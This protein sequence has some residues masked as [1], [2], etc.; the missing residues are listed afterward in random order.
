M[1]KSHECHSPKKS[2]STKSN[3][4]KII[5]KNVELTLTYKYQIFKIFKK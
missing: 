4:K 2:Q 1:R 3:K 5:D